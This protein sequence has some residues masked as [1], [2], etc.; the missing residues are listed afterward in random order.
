MSDEELE[1]LLAEAR[2]QDPRGEDPRGQDPR[3]GDAAGKA[4]DPDSA[5]GSPLEAGAPGS[6]AK[7][8]KAAT[9]PAPESGLSRLLALRVASHLTA[10]ERDLVIATPLATGLLLLMAPLAAASLHLTFAGSEEGVRLHFVL[11]LFALCFGCFNAASEVVGERALVLRERRY[12]VPVRAYLLSKLLV[13]ALLAALQCL[14]LVS[15]AARSVHFDSPLP[16]LYLVLFASA[17]CGT[18]LGL[19]VSSLAKRSRALL[20]LLPLVLLPQALAWPGLTEVPAPL[21]LVERALPPHWTLE[22][23]DALRG[24]ET[25]WVPLCQGLAGLAA[26]GLTCL[27]LAAFVLWSADEV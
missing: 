14:L 20:V 4:A 18:C 16:A 21:G 3:G 5:V 6:A 27:V 12:G 7:A 2:G 17:L 23:L 19:L 15:L 8:S 11:A 22:A 1:A 24:V 10:R 25:A 26:C 13:G 9:P